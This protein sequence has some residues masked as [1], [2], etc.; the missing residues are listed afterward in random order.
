M[1]YENVMHHASTLG[2]QWLDGDLVHAA[3]RPEAPAASSH[4][5]RQLRAAARL[6]AI[7]LWT[8]VA[9]V[10]QLILIQFPGKARIRF[11]RLFWAGVCR[12]LG[13]KIVVLGTPAGICR[14]RGAV[15]RGVRPVVY[16]SNHTSWLDI[17]ALG[18]VLPAV[19]VSKSEVSRWP[20]IKTVA[21]LGRTIFVSRQKSGTAREIYGI[22]ER[23]RVGDN[24]LLFP[25]G[26]S[27]S[28]SH[29]LPFFSSF[30]A[31]ALAGRHA[32]PEEGRN[33]VLIQPI[34]VVYDELE[35]LPVHRGRRSVFSWHGSM[36]L[37]PHIWRLAQWGSHRATVLVHPPVEPGAHLTRKDLASHVH[38]L[39]SEGA[40]RLRQNRQNEA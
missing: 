26:T 12:L 1:R 18:A 8:I 35:G 19:F 3:S 28:G 33:N 37:A 30:F 16:V 29:V 24:A 6:A 31:V 14:D 34:S 21:Q 20:F 32:T 4:L 40:A 38:Q 39:V 22:L 15:A 9:A 2:T 27:S 13:L 5:G 11:A 23:L 36:A 7:S 17:P 25:E 10:I